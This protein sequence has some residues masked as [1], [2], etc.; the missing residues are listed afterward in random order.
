MSTQGLYNRWIG[1]RRATSAL[2]SLCIKWNF[3]GGN[4]QVDLLA[5]RTQNRG[6][7]EGGGR[8]SW[9]MEEAGNSLP[10]NFISRAVGPPPVS[11]NQALTGRQYLN[12]SQPGRVWL[13][14][15]WLGTGKPLTFFYSVPPF[16]STPHSV[17]GGGGCCY[18]YILLSG[19]EKS[20][21][22]QQIKLK[23]A[24]WTVQ[25]IQRKRLYFDLCFLI[26]H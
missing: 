5:K 25:K 4:E 3:M 17:G 23:P 12:Y 21:F 14:N 20:E 6:G 7:R 18:T 1:P 8:V 10:R 2:R 11:T 9:A 22:A 15:S 26:K 19:T 24:L 16:H 13:V